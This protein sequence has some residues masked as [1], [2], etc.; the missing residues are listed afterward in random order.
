MEGFMKATRKTSTD[1][2]PA[3]FRK[4][5]CNPCILICLQDLVFKWVVSKYLNNLGANL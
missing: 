5:D 1:E 2:K 4:H 3:V